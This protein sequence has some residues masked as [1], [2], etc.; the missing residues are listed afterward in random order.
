MVISGFTAIG[1]FN[2][3]NSG[4]LP[5][6]GGLTTWASFP[7]TETFTQE[8]WWF[9]V[10]LLVATF[11]GILLGWVERRERSRIAVSD[12]VLAF[13]GAVAAIYLVAIYGTAARN[14]VGTPFVPIGV[15]FATLETLDNGKPI[16]ESHH[17]YLR[18]SP[19][20]LGSLVIAAQR[21]Q[22]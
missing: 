5:E 2:L 18:D 3:I 13:C 19:A 14:A 20:S 11:G 9:G 22:K 1:F 6:M 7:G 4:T 12:I 16:R 17:C 21:K 10:P 15:L 8:T